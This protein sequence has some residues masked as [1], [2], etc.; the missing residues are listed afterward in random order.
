LAQGKQYIIRKYHLAGLNSVNNLRS[1]TKQTYTY[2]SPEDGKKFA[3]EICPEA[4]PL[5]NTFIPN[6]NPYRIES[7]PGQNTAPDWYRI[8]E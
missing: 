2:L 3:D 8:P 1:S 7:W 5:W 6:D 4:A